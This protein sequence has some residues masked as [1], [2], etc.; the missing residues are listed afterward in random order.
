MGKAIEEPMTAEEARLRVNDWM[1]DAR[2]LFEPAE[3]EYNAL[4][5][6]LTATPQ[7]RRK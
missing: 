3:L 5:K 6:E 7:T 1:R 4:V 2:A